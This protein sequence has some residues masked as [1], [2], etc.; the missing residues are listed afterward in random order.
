MGLQNGVIQDGAESPPLDVQ[1]GLAPSW[2]DLD[3]NGVLT[4]I[5]WLRLTWSDY[6]L[7]WDP[8]DHSNITSLL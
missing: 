4:A 5:L 7:A 2:M 1:L 8:E 3:S 6:R